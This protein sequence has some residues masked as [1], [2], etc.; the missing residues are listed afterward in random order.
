MCRIGFQKDGVYLSLPYIGLLEEPSYP[1]EGTNGQPLS[2]A[3]PLSLSN[4][5]VA[6]KALTRYLETTSQVMEGT[7]S[8]GAQGLYKY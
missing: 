4:Q 5:R 8:W 1:L 7:S 2:S 3:L 6:G